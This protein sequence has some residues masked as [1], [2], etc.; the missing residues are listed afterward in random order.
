MIDESQ[1]GDIVS[2]LRKKRRRR[3]P[4]STDSL[5]SGITNGSPKQVK[6]TNQAVRM[7]DAPK[8]AIPSGAKPVGSVTDSLAAK[9]T[10]KRRPSVQ[11]PDLMRGGTGATMKSAMTVG[12]ELT[13]I[14]QKMKTNRLRKF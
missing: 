6:P 10:A 13:G 8:R 14:A 1:M 4:K 9:A 2:R 3:I 12:N 11:S 5:T 7:P